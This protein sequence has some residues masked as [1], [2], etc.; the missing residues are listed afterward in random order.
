MYVDGVM[1]FSSD[2]FLGSSS[3]GADALESAKNAAMA[4]AEKRAQSAADFFVANLLSLI[5]GG[6]EAFMNSLRAQMDHVRTLAGIVPKSDASSGGANPCW[7]DHGGTHWWV[8]KDGR[9]LPAFT[10]Q[11]Y[12]S[13]IRLPDGDITSTEEFGFGLL[14]ACPERLKEGDQFT[15]SITGT[16]NASAAGEGDTI[17]VPIVAGQA[18]FFS[19]GAGGQPVQTWTVRGSVSGALPDWLRDLDAPAPYTAA[20]SPAELEL[21]DGGIPF[22]AGDRIRVDLF[23][24]R[25]RWRRDGGAWSEA[26]IF[27]DHDVGDGLTLSARVGSA[28]AFAVG[29]RWRFAAEARYGVSKLRQPRPGEAFAWDGDSVMLT[30]TWATPQPAEVVAVAL[31]DLPPGAVLTLT[32]TDAAAV[33]TTTTANVIDGVALFRLGMQVQLAEARL[34]ITH[35]GTG[36]AIGWLFAG[37]GWRPTVGASTLSRSRQYGL[38]RGAR[39]GSGA[40]YSGRGVGGEWSWQVSDGGVLLDDTCRSLQTLLDHV[41]KHDNEP[42]LLVP[43]LSDPTLASVAVLAVAPRERG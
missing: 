12:V 30:A 4:E 3:A 37:M 9:Y 27:A 21:A 33:V 10:T 32:A 7:R 6:T 41:A 17:T 40:L 22:E 28:P 5:N 38:T 43:D 24:G 31:A 36:G 18:A 39:A 1:A 25:L 29:N 19:Y 16:A 13:A 14:V 26:D 35:A 42:V 8:D 23:A 34:S 11:P 15:I 2:Q 20:A